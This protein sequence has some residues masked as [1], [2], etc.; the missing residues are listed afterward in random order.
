MQ[1]VSPTE[2]APLRAS[3]ALLLGAFLIVA[4]GVSAQSITTPPNFLNNNAGSPGGGVYSDVTVL[5][6]GGL[7]LESFDT[8][9]SGLAGTSVTLDVYTC[10]VTSIGNELI[11]AN[12]TLQGSGT[13]LSLGPG[14]G[15]PIDTTDFVMQAGSYG[16]AIVNF[17][18]HAYTN[19]TGA[20]QTVANGEM[21]LS[22]GTAS[23]VAFVGPLFN[24]RVWNG[25]IHYAPNAN[26][27]DITQDASLNLTATLSM[28]GANSHEGFTFLSGNTS[29]PV[30]QGPLLGLTPD[31]LTWTTFTAPYAPSDPF[32]FLVTDPG[33]PTAPLVLPGAIFAGL[34]GQTMDIL[35]LFMDNTF[36]Y[37]SSSNIVR[38]TFQ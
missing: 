16:M 8:N 12:W 2:S 6:G 14:V 10:P 1:P 26:I 22:L 33:W 29:L 23:N 11:L 5:S 31:A 18:G 34:T 27:L 36:A 32:H 37:D 25:T 38:Y 30:G 13:G 28:L 9:C 19:G 3:L 24:P 15:T 35:V 7:I 21:S 17:G 4:G 20:N